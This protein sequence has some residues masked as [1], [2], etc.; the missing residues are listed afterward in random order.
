MKKLTV[1]KEIINPLVIIATKQIGKTNE[2]IGK[3]IG[4][5]P[6]IFSQIKNQRNLVGFET[7]ALMRKKYRLNINAIVDEDVNNLFSEY[8]F[9]DILEE[10]EKVKKERDEIKIERDFFKNYV[11]KGA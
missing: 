10:L 6:M 4:K 7:L 5:S 1:E 11:M 9:D 3:D 8:N 2:E